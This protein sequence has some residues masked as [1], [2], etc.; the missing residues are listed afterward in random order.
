M[1]TRIKSMEQF[2][3]CFEKGDSHEFVTVCGLLKFRRVITR[4]KNRRGSVKERYQ[5]WSMVDGS[6]AV[7]TVG[8]IG[9]YFAEAMRA[10]ALFLDD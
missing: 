4:L 5:V 1:A 7:W 2:R 9:E 8:E 6:V 3:A 10:G